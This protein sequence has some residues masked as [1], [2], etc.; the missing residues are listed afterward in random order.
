VRASRRAYSLDIA[1]PKDRP[2]APLPIDP[3]LARVADAVRGPHRAA[4]V[5]APPGSGKTTRVPPA[6]LAA[7]LPGSG[8]LL[9]LQPRRIAARA[10]AARIASERG[11][12]LGR[13]AGYQVRFENRSGPGTRIHVITEGILT[14]KLQADPTLE[15]VAGVILDEFHERSIH[16]D[17]AIALL[18]EVR[19]TIR[20]DLA[21]VVMSATLDPEPVSR[22]LGGCPVVTAEGRPFP[23]EVRHIERPDRSPLHEAA[24]RA[25][26]DAWGKSSGHAL[27]FL[28][29]IGEIRRAAREVEVLARSAG[30]LVTPLH[31]SLTLDEQEEALRPSARR[32]IVLATNIA[33]TSLT[34]D[35]VDLVIDGGLARVL[36][37]DPRHGIDRLETVRISKR[38]AEQRAGRAG[39]LG[40]GKAIRL[41]TRAEH[42]ALPDED[43]PEVRRVDLASAVL[44][45]RSWG[46]ADPRAFEWFEAPDGAVL[47]RAEDLLAALGAVEGRHGPLTAEGKAMLAI[48]AHPRISRMLIA[49]DASGRL[50]EGAALAALIEEKDIV[51]GPGIRAPGGAGDRRPESGPSDI[52]VRLDLLEEAERLGFRRDR[53][54]C[55]GVDAAAA[56]GA[57]RARDLILR[58]ARESLR[59]G[60]DAPRDRTAPGARGDEGEAAL[61]RALL[62]GYPDRV[63]RRRARGSDRGRMTGGRGVVLARE[64]VVRDAD[65]FLAIDLDEGERGERLE[66]RVWMASAVRRAWIEEAFPEAIRETA[67]TAFDPGAEKVRT[68]SAVR[69]RDLPLEDPRER[70]PD[71]AEAERALAEAARERAA[72]LFAANDEA[73][74]WLSRVRWLRDWM[75]E[76]GLPALGEEDLRGLAASACAGRTSLAEVRKADLGGIVQSALT[77]EQAAAVGRHAP[78]EIAI[79]SGRRVKLAYEP[80][81]PPVLAARLQELFG[82]ERTPALAGG[83]A[84]VLLHILGPNYRP[85]QITQDI[86][87]FW[88]TTYAQVRKDLRA[89]YPK[90]AWPEDPRKA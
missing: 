86:E 24:A 57:A 38:S 33:E 52:L 89:R 20:P 7:G 42:A 30:A 10:A 34:I 78:E 84:P 21:V 56:R 19:A 35:G 17:L 25:L 45:L 9:V 77:R 71:A 73:A 46:V 2:L 23:V 68:F 27:V 81:K 1:P 37:S 74:A 58:A 43:V 51:A 76:L 41:W 28:P 36:R 3:H 55:I 79:P 6:L 83:R 50:V 70:R 32:K 69:Y 44:E 53:L 61:L 62:H 80:G 14:R 59:R 31:G 88:R 29:G 5:V 65:L 47:E 18:R 66:A 22:F 12:T 90:H 82:L 63:C 72:D 49:A 15:G 85:V 67:E 8:R 16:T 11:W 13:E 39:R 64:S 4:V 40:P 54:A 48:P 26:R 87:S 75:P 60:R